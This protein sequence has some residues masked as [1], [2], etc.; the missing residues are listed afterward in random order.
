LTTSSLPDSASA[1]AAYS[2]KPVSDLQKNSE[3]GSGLEILLKRNKS[4]EVGS[5]LEI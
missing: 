2:G 5:G 4:S 1:N 3:V